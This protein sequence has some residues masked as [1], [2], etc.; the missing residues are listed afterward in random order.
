MEEIARRQ[1]PA[2]LQLQPKQRE[3]INL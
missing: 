2:K 1:T 3:S